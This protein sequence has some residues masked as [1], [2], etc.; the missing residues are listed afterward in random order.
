MNGIEAT[1][2]IPR[3]SK[4]AL[5]SHF[6][7]PSPSSTIQKYALGGRFRAAALAPP[8]WLKIIDFAGPGNFESRL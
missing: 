2:K 6:A 4:I 8:N 3:P 1:L 7:D 5:L